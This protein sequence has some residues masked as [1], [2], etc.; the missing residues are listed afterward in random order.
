[1]TEPMPPDGHPLPSNNTFGR[2]WLTQRV[3]VV[4]PAL[5]NL[6]DSGDPRMPADRVEW[7]RNIALY[8]GS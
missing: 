4:A 6:T 1:M 7:D 2:I 8:E 3:S 5:L